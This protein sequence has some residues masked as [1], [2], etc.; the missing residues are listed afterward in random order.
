MKQKKRFLSFGY[1]LMISYIV[2]LIV[3]VAFVGAFAY[4]TAVESIR[5]QTKA[6]IR[7][8]LQQIQDNIRYKVED[9]KRLTDSLYYDRTLADSLR[10]YDDGWYSFETLQSYLIPMLQNTVHSSN[11]N[12]ALSLYIQN[13]TIPEVYYSY[14]G[15]DPLRKEVLPAVSP[16]A[17]SGQALVQRFSPGAIR[18]N[19]AVAPD[20]R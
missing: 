8:T 14:E 12:I 6:N 2:L 10:R 3:P 18:G 1:K 9:T 17:D 16:K 13:E 4:N 20:R 11:R 15:M 5:T 7:G 19:D